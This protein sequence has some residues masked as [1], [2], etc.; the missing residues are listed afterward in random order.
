MKHLVKFSGIA[1][2]L[3][4]L[5]TACQKEE[6]NESNVEGI[7]EGTLT[8][9]QTK[10]KEGA[11]ESKPATTEISIIGKNEIQVHCYSDGFDTT[12]VL[13]YYNHNNIAYVC[14]SGDDFEEIY[15]HMLDDSHMGG[16]M[17]NNGETEW[18][19]H[20]NGQHDNSDEHFGEFDMH[21][22]SFSYIFRMNPD[23]HSDDLHFQGVK[24]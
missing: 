11:A 5:F 23:D 12:F 14:Y 1:I 7:Y 3:L 17:H 2:A 10:D 21:R 24:Q 8:V 22:Q 9:L 15:G 16:V 4:V 6:T 20:M 19:R 18:M 13:N